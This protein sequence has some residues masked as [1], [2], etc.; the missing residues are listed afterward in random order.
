VLIDP[1]DTVVMEQPGYFGAALAFT[2]SQANVVG[3]GVDARA[4][5]RRAGARP[6]R[7]A[8]EAHL[9]DAA[10]QAPTGSS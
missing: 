3:V 4:P 5:D 8:R 7:A 1:G 9:H 10:A 6:S 2:A